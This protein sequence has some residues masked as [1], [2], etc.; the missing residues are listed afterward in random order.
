VKSVVAEK[1]Q[2]SSSSRAAKLPITA[3]QASAYE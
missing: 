1:K 3:V 2:D